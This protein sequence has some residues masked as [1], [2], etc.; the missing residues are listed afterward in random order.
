MKYRYRMHSHEA[1]LSCLTDGTIYI[2]ARIGAVGHNEGFVV[3]GASF[4]Y[5]MHCTDVSVEAGS[6]ILDVEQHD[7]DVR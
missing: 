6:Y 4:H 2:V 1:F 3:F 7:I 5:I